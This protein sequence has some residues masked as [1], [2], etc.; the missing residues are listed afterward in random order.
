[1]NQQVGG[2]SPKELTIGSESQSKLL[3]GIEMISSA[4]KSTLGP[5]GQTVIIESPHH[6]HGL[7]VTKDGVTVAK[8]YDMADP[9]G[10]LAVKMMKE[11]SSRTATSAGDGTTTAIV[12]TEAL[13]KQGLK[14]ITTGVNKTEVL[15]HIVSET[16]VLVKS[17]KKKSKKVT[18]KRLVDVATI[19]A[20]NDKV[21]GRI[22]SDCYNEVGQ[23]G[24]V[25]VENSPTPDTFYETTQGI[26][27]DKGYSSPMFIN[28]QKKDECILDDVHILVC[29]SEVS[30]ILQIE[31]V[32]KPI[33]QDKKKLLIISPCTTNV[34]ATLAANVQKR[35]LQICTIPPPNF[36]YRQHELMQDIALSV[37]ATYFSEKTG[38]DLSLIEF[39]DLGFASRVIV[40]RDS[41]VILSEAEENKDVDQRVSELWD[42]H[43]ATNQ[44]QDKDFILQRI[45]SL[46]G[47]VGVIHVGGNT[48]LEQKELYDRVDDAVCA[49]RSA[50]EEGILPGAGMALS[51][52]SIENFTS[53][54]DNELSIAKKILCASLQAPWKQIVINAGLDPGAIEN[55]FDYDNFNY[56][57][58]LK[59]KEYGDLIE[60]GVIDPT[61]VTRSALQNAVSVAVTILS[62]NAIITMA[63]TY[64]TE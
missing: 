60:M 40:G 26:K 2:Y 13:V 55:D 53:D 7:T 45:A 52:V 24:I 19:S 36:G 47:G 30:N 54:G 12:L 32:L 48:D 10:N 58:N 35:G 8:S 20:N 18:K 28:H 34:I 31:N 11:A 17:L 63:R 9:V 5:M 16:E 51:F 29:D 44:K 56:G 42:A 49:V 43:K 62:T 15:R 50:L 64:E 3:H 38:D 27:V 14:Y 57:Y 1:M 39:T 33:I 37:G 6:L 46:T 59:T 4:V 23:N 61:K 21:I 22:I 41:S 25:T